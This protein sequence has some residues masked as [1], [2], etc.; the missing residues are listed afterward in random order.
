MYAVRKLAVVGGSDAGAI[1]HLLDG[2]PVMIPYLSAGHH[3]RDD[4]AASPIVSRL[5]ATGDDLPRHPYTGEPMSLVEISTGRL[6]MIATDRLGHATTCTA[7]RELWDE[8]DAMIDHLPDGARLY[9]P[10][11]TPV[12]TVHGEATLILAAPLHG[13]DGTT[14]MELVA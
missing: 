13:P 5:V 14:S 3:R 1:G 11:P 10:L 7:C 12:H 9:E 8:L 2:D 4:P 6:I